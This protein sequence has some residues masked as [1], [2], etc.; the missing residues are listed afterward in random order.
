[1]SDTPEPW[2]MADASL[3][4]LEMERIIEADWA[5]GHRDGPRKAAYLVALAAGELMGAIWLN[6]PDAYLQAVIGLVV[7]AGGAGLQAEK[8]AF[9]AD[10]GVSQ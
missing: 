3:V 10:G 8:W 6:S 1:M 9:E 7:A 2:S 5:A 4:M